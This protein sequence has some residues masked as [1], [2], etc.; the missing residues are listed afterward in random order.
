MAKKRLPLSAVKAPVVHRA[1]GKPDQET[2]DVG[3]FPTEIDVGNFPAIQDVNVVSPDPLPVI[4]EDQIDGPTSAIMTV[5]YAHHEIHSGSHYF[6]TSHHDI[7]KNS[8]L[9]HLVITPNTAKWA[10]MVIGLSTN[11]GSVHVE[12]FE[13]ATVSNNGTLEDTPNRNRNSANIATTLIYED[14]TVTAVGDLL[15]SSI[16]GADSKQKSIGGDGRDNN[17]IILKQNTIYLF[18]ATELNVEDCTINLSF[19]W[20]EHTNN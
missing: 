9:D 1:T 16:F 18:R 15:Y 20:Y 7:A 4:Q 8:V 14:P 17:E 11:A 5:D 2:I 19:D 6:Y 13:A 12:F 10:H 3:N